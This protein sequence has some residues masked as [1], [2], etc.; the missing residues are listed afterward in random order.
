MLEGGC[1][2]SDPFRNPAGALN[3]LMAP[4]GS[5]TDKI[6][7]ARLRH[8]LLSR[9]LHAVWS[10]PNIPT[11][12]FLRQWGFSERII[13]SFF[14]PFLAGIFLEPELKTSARM[15][16][17]VYRCFSKG[18]ASLPAGGMAAIPIQLEARLP[19]EA[20]RLRSRVER[21][22]VGR[23][24]LSSGELI[25]ARSVVVATDANQAVSWF[26]Q[27]PFRPWN[28][29]TTYYFDAPEAPF[30]ASRLLW[31]NATGSG[32]VNHL[33]VPSSVAG[34]YAPA[35]RSLIS[36]TSLH[37][38]PAG[39][40]L[41]PLPILNELKGYFGRA[42]SEWRFLRAYPISRALPRLFPEDIEALD[43]TIQPEAGI[44]LCGDFLGAGSLD[45]A[46]ASGITAARRCLAGS[47][48]PGG[49][50]YAPL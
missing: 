32:A 39:E 46:M 34:G 21:I 35:G 19:A 36:A 26:P 47:C 37:V 17:F 6:R 16:A 50:P 45:G 4:I 33:A 7:I 44:Y 43:V 24:E 48:A 22:A 2:V 30:P 3:T 14:R 15:F 5:V 38:P 31:L 41:D 25:R 10:L 40:E 9:P 1:T 20:V 42:V 49:N 11:H 8:F 28:G 27:V 23:V 13:A 29:G 18:F 12:D